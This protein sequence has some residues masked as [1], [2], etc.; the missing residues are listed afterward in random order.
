MASFRAF[1]EQR[2]AKIKTGWTFGTALLFIGCRSQRGDKLYAEEFEKWERAGAVQVFYAFSQE[3]EA[4]YGCKYVQERIYRE[5][6]TVSS[7]F[8]AG[9]KVF[10]CGSGRLGK[11]VKDVSKK[12]FV[13]RAK[14]FGEEKSDEE[15]E[16]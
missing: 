11:G 16:E 9:A 4:S 6:E 15:I 7:L 1:V 13:E 14:E 8:A 10:V 2:A 12:I 3:K 5:K